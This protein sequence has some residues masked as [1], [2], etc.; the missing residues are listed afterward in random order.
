MKTKNYFLSKITALVFLFLGTFAFAQA[1]VAMSYQAVVRDDTGTLMSNKTIGVKM[2]VLKTSAS[3]TVVYAETF[4][5]KPVTNSNGLMTLEIGKGTPTTGTF[6]GIDWSAGP[7]FVK[8][9]IDPAGGTTYSVVSTSQLLSVP[10]ALYAKTAGS[11]AGFTLP[12]AGTDAGTATEK[13]KITNSSATRSNAGYFRN[14]SSTNDDPTLMVLNDSSEGYGIGI[15][16]YARA[17]ISNKTS[18]AVKGELLGSGPTGSGVHGY[19]QNAIGV[20]G[21]TFSGQAVYGSTTGNGTG[22]N[23]RSGSAGYALKTSGRLQLED[24][25]E[26]AGKVLT[27]D[28]QGNA[29]WQTPSTQTATPKVHF[30]SVGGSYQTIGNATLPTTINSWRFLNE[31][32]GSNYNATTG[33]YTIPVTGYYSV[34]AAIGFLGTNNLNGSPATLHIIVDGG[35]KK[36]AVSNSAVNGQNYSDISVNLEDDFTAGQKIKIGVSQKGAVTLD[37]FDP[38]TNFSIH[39]IH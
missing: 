30:S 16:G 34:K 11:G 9:E 4:T 8:S 21:M 19:A 37:L 12:Y 32:G 23:F 18:Y 38:S 35:N 2:S 26:G 14:S 3:G 28:A 27:S 15:L 31:S 1:P 17:N 36:V 20:H 5:P 29:T 13:F 39:L 25:G 10:Y 6:S 22:G 24:I 33:E 7:Y